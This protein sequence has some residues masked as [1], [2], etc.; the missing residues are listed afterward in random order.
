MKTPLHTDTQQ[1]ARLQDIHAYSDAAAERKVAFHKIGKTWAR[2]LAKRTGLPI[3]TYD[4]RSNQGGIAVSGEVTLHAEHFYLQLSESAISGGGGIDIMYR[5]CRGRKD[6]SGGNNTFALMTA[7]AEDSGEA[8]DR[9][10]AQCVAMAGY[11]ETE[12]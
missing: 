1:L 12:A 4:I 8:L 11:V 10:V 7:L 5:T 9:F 3:G 2:H 6:Y